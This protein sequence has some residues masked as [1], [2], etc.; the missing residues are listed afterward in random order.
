MNWC[1]NNEQD[2]MFSSNFGQRSHD[3]QIY[4]KPQQELE[5]QLQNSKPDIAKQTSH[6]CSIR[7]L[8]IC[9]KCYTTVFCLD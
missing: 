3:L 7:H 6:V 2:V 8:K 9:F 5:M 4:S 1:M